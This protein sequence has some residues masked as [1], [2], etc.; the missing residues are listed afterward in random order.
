MRKNLLIIALFCCVKMFCFPFVL[1]AQTIVTGGF[2]G[3]ITDPT[4]S[5]VPGAT[6]ALTSNTTGDIHSTVP[7][8]TGAYVF[9]PLKPGDYTLTAVKDGFKTATQE[10]T[11]LLGQNSTVNFAMELGAVTTTVEVTGEGNLLQTQDANIATTFD[12]EQFNYARR[13]LGHEIERPEKR[14]LGA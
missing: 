2:S 4:G 13:G 9:S 5:T 12:R 14:D 10:I 1:P 6:L 7:S 3:T 11:V 8:S